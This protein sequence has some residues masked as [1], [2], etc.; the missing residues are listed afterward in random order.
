MN[1]S[2][3]LSEPPDR[4]SRRALP[5]SSNGFSFVGS[6]ASASASTDASLYCIVLLNMASVTFVFARPSS[7]WQSV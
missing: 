3:M 4:L 6:S 7:K 5:V 1:V 2:A